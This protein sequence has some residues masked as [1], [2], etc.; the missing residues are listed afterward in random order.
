MMWLNRSI[1]IINVIFKLL[2]IYRYRFVQ[3]DF[4]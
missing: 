2:D 1:T 3:F 4:I